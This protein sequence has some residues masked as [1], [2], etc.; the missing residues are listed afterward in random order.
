MLQ[1]RADLCERSG[2]TGRQLSIT[3]P[4]LELEELSNLLKGTEKSKAEPG[5]G[6]RSP[7]RCEAEEIG[8]KP[9]ADAFCLKSR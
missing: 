6:C 2:P 1:L 5:A 7:D 9:N 4:S 8:T 3:V